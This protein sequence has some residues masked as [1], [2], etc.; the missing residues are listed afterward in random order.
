MF[1]VCRISVGRSEHHAPINRRLQEMG[2]SCKLPK[3]DMVSAQIGPSIDFL[4][5]RQV[6]NEKF[7]QIKLSDKNLYILFHR[8]LIKQKAFAKRLFCWLPK[9]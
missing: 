4:I 7:D 3:I 1:P 2:I 6:V 9:K 8:L 5:T